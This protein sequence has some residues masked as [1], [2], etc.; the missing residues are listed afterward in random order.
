M[1]SQPIPDRHGQHRPD[2]L[3][4]LAA[5]PDN[6]MPVEVDVLDA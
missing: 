1:H 4:T 5:A 6:L 3:L 2:V